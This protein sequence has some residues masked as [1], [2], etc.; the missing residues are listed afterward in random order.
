VALALVVQAAVAVVADLLVANLEVQVTHQAR[1]HHKVIMVVLVD[2]L[3]TIR[4]PQ[5]AVEQV[6]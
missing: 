5:A 2:L 3:A 1:H 4:E 6:Q